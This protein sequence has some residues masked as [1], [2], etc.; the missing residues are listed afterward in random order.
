LVNLSHIYFFFK[1][2]VLENKNK[3]IKLMIQI[4]IKLIISKMKK[5]KKKYI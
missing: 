3:I 4:I 5:S 1:F 2:C